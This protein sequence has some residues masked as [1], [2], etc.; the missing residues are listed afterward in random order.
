MQ[1]SSESH[2]TKYLV[3]SMLSVVGVWATAYFLGQRV[4]IISSDFTY[5]PLTTLL[6]ITAFFQV[7]QVRKKGKNIRTW[8]IFAVF[9][10]SYNIAQHIWSL[11]ELI[12]DQKPFP[13]F[14]DVAYVI[15]TAS[16]AIFLILFIRSKKQFIAKWMFFISILSSCLLIS[17]ATYVFATN[18]IPNNVEQISTLVYLILDGIALA[19]ATIG[20]MMY[21][22][23]K[24]N[25]AEFLICVSM[26]PLIT[27]DILFQI[28]TT[29]GTYYSGSIPD[30]FHYIQ[31]T[32][33]IFGVYIIS[34]RI[35]RSNVSVS[36]T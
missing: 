33:L 26:M 20:I 27:G 2:I 14:A 29:N 17:I 30:L 23:S 7:Y 18:Y 35:T 16:L 24:L 25:F 10:L 21:F 3:L 12:T 32:L 8:Y 1:V 31:I 22:K 13:S 34:N 28:T 6:T 5:I 4:S 9:A 36:Q 19:P 11:N 15:D